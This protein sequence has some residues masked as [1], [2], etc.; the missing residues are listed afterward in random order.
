MFIRQEASRARSAH[1][2]VVPGAFAIA[3]IGLFAAGVLTAAH[4]L[5][6]PIPC[7]RSRGC[8]TVALHPSSQIFGVP[9]AAIGFAAYL[10][11]IFLL[12]RASLNRRTRLSLAA[13]SG[14]GT[15]V[16]AGL[17]AYAHH[18]IHA[19]CA[20]CVVSSVAMT[21]L[22]ISALCLLKRDEVI[23]GT[24]PAWIW[25]LAFVT[26]LALGVQ[27]GS[28]QKTALM[29]PVTAQHLAAFRTDELID[30]AKSLGPI[31]APVTI[32]EF[33]DLSCWACRNSY[34]SLLKYQAANRAGV[35]LVLRHLPLW[36]IRGHEFSR[37]AAAVSEMMAEHD[38]FW[39]FVAEAYQR[40]NHLERDVILELAQR[41]DFDL[42]EVER[43]LGDPGDR[44]IA[45]VMQ[46]ESLADRLGINQTP[47][48]IV[49]V[50][51]HQPISANQRTL[52]R[53]LNA[54]EV[55]SHL[56]RAA[57]RDRR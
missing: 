16:S 54:P 8:L 27:A 48:F 34:E 18:V 13:L 57:A 49:I 4:L 55:T 24:K 19:T 26:A 43:R 42:Q 32:I 9:I 3:C 40:H 51:G 44:A 50:N 14:T 37:A 15:A 56:A 6:L 2:P 7:G 5:D 11:A 21:L 33:A 12:A 36:Q 28:M 45:R 30:P 25:S 1:S 39:P 31:D 20:W 46:D 29:P 23:P 53:F 17:L 47:T 10:A 38:K 35:R 52:P 22:F 41:F